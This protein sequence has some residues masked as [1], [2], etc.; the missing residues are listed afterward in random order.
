MDNDGMSFRE[1]LFMALMF[2]GVAGFLACSLALHAIAANLPWII[3]A[4]AAGFCLA[5]VTVTKCYL[6][7]I[8]ARERYYLSSQH[9]DYI[10]AGC[11]AARPSAK[12]R[13]LLRRE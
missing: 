7:V 12:I 6:R 13:G 10:D 11:R 1:S 4:G 5:V 9:Y 8:E 2:L 3:L